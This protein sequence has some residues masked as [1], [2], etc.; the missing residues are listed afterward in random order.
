VSVVGP[1]EVAYF[2]GFFDGE[3]SIT[4]TQHRPHGRVANTYVHI[5]IGQ[6][7]PTPLLRFQAL[8]GGTMRLVPGS[9]R[10]P[11]RRSACWNLRLDRRPAVR[12]L[13][14]M[15]P[16]LIVKRAQADLALAFA[17]SRDQRPYPGQSRS[18]SGWER[19]E[20]ASFADAF[21]QWRG[22]A[23]GAI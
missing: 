17:G 15:R 21:A 1:S 8:F 3:G 7:D 10:G 5:V 20:Q 2:A 16:Y 9:D 23:L 18:L 22:R 19:A 14:A 4:V 6:V 12:A 11:I 13:R